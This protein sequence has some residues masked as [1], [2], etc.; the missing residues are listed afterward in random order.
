MS[1]SQDIEMDSLLALLKK[2]KPDTT[3]LIH[4]YQ[5]SD[6]CETNGIYYTGLNYG[7]Q[8]LG[9]ANSLIIRTDSNGEIISTCK[10]Y[11]GKALSNIGVIYY[12]QGNYPE[13]LKNYFA[14]LKIMEEIADKKGIASAFNNIGI[15]YD[16]QGNYSEALK[17]YS[18]SLKIKKEIGDNKGIASAHNN[19]GVV[20]YNM[21]NFSEALKNH[22]A[23]LEIKKTLG[24]KRNLA[25]SYNNIGNVY[26]S[27]A[28]NENDPKLSG[29]ITIIRRVRK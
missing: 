11:K 15:I 10:K 23:S 6:Y 9:L 3:K 14:S 12:D 18:A 27:E 26:S 25:Y 16:E 20:Y 29:S 8:A 22:L 21:R 4:L 5:L 7:Y 1:F 17:N 13:A 28:N 24:N 19:L 2:D